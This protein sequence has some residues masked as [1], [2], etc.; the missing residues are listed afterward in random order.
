ML[1]SFSSSFANFRLF[2]IRNNH[3]SNSFTGERTNKLSKRRTISR[4]RL[5]NKR[6]ERFG[7]AEEGG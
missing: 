7:S 6:D 2:P 5:K 4:S 3:N 1:F